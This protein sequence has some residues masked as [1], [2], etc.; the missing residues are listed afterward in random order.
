MEYYAKG[1]K[2][3][4]ALLEQCISLTFILYIQRHEERVIIPVNDDY[5]RFVRDLVPEIQGFPFTLNALCGYHY[6]CKLLFKDELI[7]FEPD[8]FKIL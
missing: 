7:F 5:D 3:P 1:D 4:I 2:N 6:V 8:T